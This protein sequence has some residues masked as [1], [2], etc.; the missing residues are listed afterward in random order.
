MKLIPLSDITE[1]FPSIRLID[2]DRNSFDVEQNDYWTAKTEAEYNKITAKL[3]KITA[4][5][6]GYKIY[7]WYDVSGFEYWVEQQRE[8][9]YAQI[10]LSFDENIT[11]VSKVQLASIKTK[12][13]K[14]IE[15]V[16]ILIED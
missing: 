8:H 13:N 12:L 5:G 16:N 9:N 2:A 3:N 1:L 14:V 10:T 15:K 4:K 6:K 11:G 7:V